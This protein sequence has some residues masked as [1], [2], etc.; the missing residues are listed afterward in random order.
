MKNLIVKLITEKTGISGDEITK[1]IEVPHRTEMGDFAF[2][3]FGLA[4]SLKKNP[5]KI[6][7][8]LAESLKLPKSIEEV[9]NEGAYV[10][11]FVNKK[12]L[13]KNILSKVERK[14]FGENKFGKNKKIVIDMA[15]PNI[16]KPF[17]I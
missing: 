4:K 6:A 8:D 1:L 15:S 10:N 2:P 12:L 9:K 16:A 13:A 14:D 7:E 11:F 17:G 5:V 3:C